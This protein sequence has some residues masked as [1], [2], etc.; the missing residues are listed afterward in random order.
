[1]DY[2]ALIRDLPNYPVEGVIF[3]DLT[4]LW[5]NGEAFKSAIDDLYDLIKDI[6]FDKVVGIE[7]RGF[8]FGSIIAHKKGVGFVPVRKKNKLPWK[9][10]SEEYAL[11]YGTDIIEIHQDAIKPGEKALIVDDLLATGGTTEAAIK[12]IRQIKDADVAA[13]AFLVELTFLNGKEKLDIPSYSLIQ[14]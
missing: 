3:R 1:M 14:Y 9:T 12:L 11:E 6:H 10:Y 5:Q 2:K 7:A 8:I 4:T 13:A